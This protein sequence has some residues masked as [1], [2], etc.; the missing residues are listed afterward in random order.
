MDGDARE[1]EEIKRLRWRI[2]TLETVETE[3]TRALAALAASE[4]RYRRLLDEAGFPITISSVRDSAILYANPPACAMFGLDNP[5]PSG[6][7]ME[8]FCP[9]PGEWHRLVEQVCAQGVVSD[10]EVITRDGRG[11]S[12]TLIITA[13]LISYEGQD[14]LLA[15]S[16]DITDRRHAEALFRSLVETSP[17]GIGIADLE[18]VIT[19]AS[20][21]AVEIFGY[22]RQ[23][24]L[25]G[26]NFRDLVPPEE[27]LRALERLQSILTGAPTGPSEWTGVRRDGRTFPQETNGEVL[28]NPDGTPRAFFFIVRDLSNRK[29]MERAVRWGSKLESLGL[30]A[31][32]IAHELNNA[33]QVTH[34][35]LELAQELARGNAQ[36]T[37]VLAG[38]EGGVD[39]ATLLAREMLAY[40]GQTLRVEAPLTMDRMVQELLELRRA[41]LPPGIRLESNS[42][43]E[44]P[45]VH[46]DED[47]VM[48]VLSALVLNAI[49]A[50]PD[51]GG[52][53]V[54]ATQ[55]KALAAGDCSSGFWPVA[56]R[57]GSF[58]MLEVR[59]SGMG[60]SEATLERICDPFYT[61]KGQ[62]RGLGLSA[63]LGILRAHS[64]CLQILSQPGAGTTIRVY[65][66]V[67]T[68]APSVAPGWQGPSPRALGILVAEDE[69]SILELVVQML[70]TWGYSP[71][72]TA[73]NG[74]EALELFRAHQDA[75]GLFLTDATMPKMSGAEAFDAMRKLQPSLR[76][77][78]M[79][80]YSEAFGRGTAASF[81][82]TGFLQKPFRFAQLKE[83]LEAARAATGPGQ[84][85]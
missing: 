19:Y 85:A 50:M 52:S 65:F 25:L 1:S 14:A 54:V 80:G 67:S 44:L 10:R 11:Q 13:S 47:Q 18:G 83:K 66:P 39:R 76:S 41:G 61:T 17:D 59:D 20:P 45:I 70:S 6:G 31:T 42:T 7:R 16:N 79:S 57:E 22:D 63:V 74:A 56:G 69:A 73:R 37:R 75:I 68:Q 3:C 48:K 49:E 40:S 43:G 84:Y 26:R 64:A 23:E 62:G 55:A 21:R 82:F 32:G 28:R 36:L 78:L 34:G 15:T 30:M 46:G 72:F 81:G 29:R 12:R 9:D 51:R 33:F 35:N 24:Q 8:V 71:I 53:V 77:V 5:K 58:L 4:T 38:I 60:I 2:A 27:H